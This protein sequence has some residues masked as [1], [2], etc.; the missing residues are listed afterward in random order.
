[1][2]GIRTR[3]TVLPSGGSRLQSSPGGRNRTKS[4][5]T[6]FRNSKCWNSVGT[7]RGAT[8]QDPGYVNLH[9]GLPD[10]QTQAGKRKYKGVPGWPYKDPSNF[11][12]G[13]DWMLK[14]PGKFTDIWYCLSLQKDKGTNKRGNPKAVRL[15]ANAIGLKAIWVDIDIKDDPKCYQ[16]QDEAL[17][18]ILEFQRANMLPEPS[19]IVFSGGEFMSTGSARRRYYRM[20][21][22][23]LL[24]A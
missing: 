13:L 7:F 16:T 14:N 10:N 9:F 18:A 21:G 15:K 22:I 23:S 19:A 6:V 24:T 1:V 11:V 12:T 3:S 5:P 8:P 17:K 20:S 2:R 4:P